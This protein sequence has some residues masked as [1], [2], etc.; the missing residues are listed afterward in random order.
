MNK[1]ADGERLQIDGSKQNHTAVAFESAGS[2]SFDVSTLS[3]EA[4]TATV[5]LDT[6]SEDTAKAKFFVEATESKSPPP[7]SFQK[8]S[9][10]SLQPPF[11]REQRRSPLRPR[12]TE[13]PFSATRQSSFPFSHSGYVDMTSLLRQQ[14]INELQNPL[15]TNST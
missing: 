13:L 4:F 14:Q 7:P 11:P 6:S 8:E 12:A 1:R 9:L 10:K 5:G 2:A 3:A 15:K